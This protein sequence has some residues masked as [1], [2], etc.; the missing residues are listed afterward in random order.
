MHRSRRYFGVS[1]KLIKELK[2]ES[3]V[4]FLKDLSKDEKNSYLKNSNVF[5]MPSISYKKSV[6]GFGI[7]YVEAAQYGVPSLVERLV[8]HPTLL[9][10]MKLVYFVMEITWMKSIKV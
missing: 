3:N 9:S 10:I 6:E 7:V 5:V 2:L 4:L 1:E 8:V